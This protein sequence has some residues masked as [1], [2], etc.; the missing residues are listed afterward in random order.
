MSNQ[1]YRIKAF[2]YAHLGITIFKH[3]VVG[4]ITAVLPL[5][6]L[7]VLNLSIYFA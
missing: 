7:G 5:I 3:P 6:L 4:I 2:D 1:N